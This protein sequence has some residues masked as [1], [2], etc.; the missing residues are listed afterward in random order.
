MLRPSGLTRTYPSQQEQRGPLGPTVGGQPA[1][2]DGGGWPRTLFHQ[3]GSVYRLDEVAL[4]EEV[5]G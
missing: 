3:A 1:P 2:A 5:D 4:R